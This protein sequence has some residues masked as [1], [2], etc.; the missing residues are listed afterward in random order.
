MKA[1]IAVAYTSPLSR[2]LLYTA[3]YATTR[4][5]TTSRRR[6]YDPRIIYEEISRTRTY[7]EESSG[8][9]VDGKR[10]KSPL[11]SADPALT[12]RQFARANSLAKDNIA[13][14]IEGEENQNPDVTRWASPLRL[15]IEW[16]GQSQKSRATNGSRRRYS[17]E[18]LVCEGPLVA[19]ES[20]MDIGSLWSLRIFEKNARDPEHNVGANDVARG[21]TEILSSLWVKPPEHPQSAIMKSMKAMLFRVS[22]HSKRKKSSVFVTQSYAY[23]ARAK[24]ESVVPTR[25]EQNKRPRTILRRAK[26]ARVRIIMLVSVSY[27]Q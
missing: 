22:L 9:N 6:S 26:P 24:N 5:S 23:A 17:R 25:K 20:L 7:E 4:I 18:V 3:G 19:E 2:K 10:L 16:A 1:L 14:A 11:N 15:H 21:W 12:R 27:G 8:C 13:A